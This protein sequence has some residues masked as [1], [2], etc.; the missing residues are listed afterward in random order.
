M[1]MYTTSEKVCF[2]ELIQIQRQRLKFE[3]QIE[4][5]KWKIQYMYLDQHVNVLAAATSMDLTSIS[6]KNDA[7]FIVTSDLHKWIFLFERIWT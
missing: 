3:M 4:T 5:V 7:V 6:I 2:D 1:Y